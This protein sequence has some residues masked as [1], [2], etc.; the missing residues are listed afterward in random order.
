MAKTPEPLS[1]LNSLLITLSNSI[2]LPSDIL[3]LTSLIFRLEQI[4]DHIS[5]FHE[6]LDPFTQ[7]N[8]IL[9]LKSLSRVKPKK[10]ILSAKNKKPSTA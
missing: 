4:P 8:L 1:E 5:K 10:Q 9:E 6:N 7:I 2:M 3:H